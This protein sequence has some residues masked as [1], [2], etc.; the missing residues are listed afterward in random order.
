MFLFMGLG[1]ANVANLSGSTIPGLT[2]DTNNLLFVAT[3]FG[4]SL[5]INA[6]IFYRVSGSAFNPAITLALAL[7]RSVTPIRG[8][9]FFIA[10][11]VGGITAAAIVESLSPDGLNAATRLG[12][13]ISVSRGM[14]PHF[15]YLISM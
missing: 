12:G 7:A 1:A 10:Q 3:T 4:L 8:L 2:V 13:G 9:L 5:M 6:W 11:I 14:S 15:W